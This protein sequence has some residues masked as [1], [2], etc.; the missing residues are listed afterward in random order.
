MG[1]LQRF[2]QRLGTLVE[3]S[4]ARLFR[5]R[6]EPVE[7]AA[8]LAREADTNKAVGPQRVL[9]PNVYDIELGAAD[10][11]RLA[12]YALTLADELAS[13]VREHAAEQGYSF[14]GPVGVVLKEHA[15]LSTGS[16]RIDSR[17]EAG[18]DD[19]ALPPIDRPTQRA[20]TFTPPRTPVPPIAPGPIGVPAAAPPPRP[21]F[22]NTTVIPAP[23][24]ARPVVFGHLH[25]PDGAKVPVGNQ[26]LTIGR[27]QDADIRLA[28]S[29][30]SRKHARVSV[31]DGAVAIEDLGS[32]NG[33][34]VN[35]QKVSRTALTIGDSI[36]LGAAVL[37]FRG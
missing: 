7:L 19:H 14:V 23:E 25:L 4:F 22:A 17:V 33:T 12:P 31:T 37:H 5:G 21:D 26:P 34:A 29:S 8:A 10:F 30:V 18:A 9:V 15:S 20:T 28:D 13:M 2:E 35:G 32:T 3:G 27:G 6:V 11:Q 1:G 36:N 24:P 16:F